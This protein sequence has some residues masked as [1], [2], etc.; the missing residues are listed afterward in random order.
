RID[1][2]VDEIDRALVRET[3][4]VGQADANRIAR[5]GALALARQ[6][7]VA[8]VG[9]FVA[10]EVHVH[11]VLRDQR[12]Q[13]G[14]VGLG[15]VAFGDHG[16]ADAAVDRRAD[17]GELQVQP[18]RGYRGLGR[19]HA[20]V[21]LRAG[22]LAGLE[23]LARDRLGLDQRLRAR[24]L[25]LREFGFG[26][27]ALQLRA[28]LVERCLV[29]TRVDHEQQV[30]LLHFLA[31]LEGHALYVAA[32]AR[33]Q[34]DAFHR[35][36]AAVEAVPLVHGLAQHGGDADLGRWRHAFAGGGLA[37]AAG[38]NGDSDHRG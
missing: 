21:A 36:D 35:G 32:H 30:A 31:F 27:G 33:A 34:L 37:A 1:L 11:R 16:A 2:V 15:E 38:G 25:R 24:V 17:L 29:G 6:F 10:L 9:L 13:Q 14:R 12:G 8:Q 19:A 20:G 5:A 18:G 22:G 4:L 28:G 23:L 26:A 3:V 7:G